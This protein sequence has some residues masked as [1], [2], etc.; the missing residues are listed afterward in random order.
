[1][2]IGPLNLEKPVG[3]KQQYVSSAQLGGYAVIFCVSKCGEFH[4]S[5]LEGI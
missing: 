4:G 1:L 3:K 5:V 2:L